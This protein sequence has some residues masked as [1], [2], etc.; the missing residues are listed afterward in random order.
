MST[1]PGAGSRRE[2]L[3]WL[4]HRGR[5]PAVTEPESAPSPQAAT[6]PPPPPPPPRP[7]PALDWARARPGETVILGR[8]QP[9]LR[10][11]R[12]QCGVGALSI[13]AAL[14]G[15]AG[16]VL[17]GC[18]Y[19]L[20]SGQSALLPGADGP[21]LAPPGSRRPVILADHPTLTLDLLQSREIQRLVVFAYSPAGTSVSWGGTLVVRTLGGARIEVPLGRPEG[22]GALVALS[23][24]NI[25]G[26]FVL[27]AEDE[28]VTGAAR[29]VC[30]AY[31]FDQI[32][33]VDDQ[34]PLR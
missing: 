14:P 23:L 33:W 30:A 34:T 9:T 28:L 1:A 20:R 5:P 18:A 12:I 4:R 22:A 7:E 15:D 13:R 17:L 3:P 24:Y 27:R 11:T 19:Q 2:D 21:S 26:E 6:L 32:T 10:L 25:D 31:G 29:Q 16:V 8:Q